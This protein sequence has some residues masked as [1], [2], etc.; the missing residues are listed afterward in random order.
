MHLPRYLIITVIM[1]LN[2]CATLHIPDEDDR[3]LAGDKYAH[4]LVSSAISAGIANAEI[5]K[6]QNK[7]VAARIA[8]GVTL[9]IGA[10]KEIYDKYWKKTRYSYKDMTWDA[11]GSALGSLAGSNCH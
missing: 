4:L 3:W 1:L 7:C 10:G 9:T 11:I 2:G 8:F 6:G 5:D